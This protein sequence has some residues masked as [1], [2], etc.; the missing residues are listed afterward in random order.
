[1]TGS[2]AS[3]GER[4]ARGDDLG[5]L[6]QS[7][8]RRALTIVLLIAL[9]SSVAGVIYIAANPPETTDPYTEFYIFGPSGNASGYPTNLTVGESGTFTVGLTN[10]EHQ[11]TTYAVVTRIGDRTETER[12]VT[13]GDEQTWESN[14][15]FS[16]ESPGRYQPQILLYKDGTAEGEPDDFL[17]LWVN[18]SESA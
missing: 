1:M 16:A 18:V 13:V 14:E 11:S 15:T 5:M 4:E 12:T 9:V 6:P 8:V 17:R 2:D 3:N 7:P 10:H